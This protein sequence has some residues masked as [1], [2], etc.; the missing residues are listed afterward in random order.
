MKKKIINF[1]KNFIQKL[2]S[3]LLISKCFNMTVENFIQKL[4][5]NLP[6]SKCFNMTVEIL[7]KENFLFL[8]LWSE[9]SVLTAQ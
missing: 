7:D 9:H 3:N 8:R 6:I 2:F 1:K 5:S 4:F